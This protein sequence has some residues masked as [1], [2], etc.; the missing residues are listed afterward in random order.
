MAAFMSLLFPFTHAVNENTRRL[1]AKNNAMQ[2]AIATKQFHAEYGHL[3]LSS[4][5]DSADLSPENGVLLDVLRARDEQ[6]NPRGI[7][8]FE[9]RED[10]FRGSAL[11]DPWGQPYRIV[12]DT[13]GDGQINVG[14][15]M[16][17]TPVA[18]WS[19]GKNGRD[20]AGAGDDIPSW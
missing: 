12:L 18:V 8:F 19:I 1:D 14:N 5:N 4:A 2:L 11:V 7:V 9:S 15:K 13:N 6:E 17:R 10:R 20:E 16:L 3:P